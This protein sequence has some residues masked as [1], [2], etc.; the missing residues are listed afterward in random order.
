MTGSKTLFITTHN[1]SV[2]CFVILCF[3][4]FG[5]LVY[6]DDVKGS[7]ELWEQPGI[8]SGVAYNTIYG[9]LNNPNAPLSRIIVGADNSFQLFHKDYPSSGQ[10]YPRWQPSPS[11][12]GVFIHLQGSLY[13]PHFGDGRRSEAK[14]YLSS[15]TPWTLETLGLVTGNGSAS[16]PYTITVVTYAGTKLK[17]EMTLTYIDVD[18]YFRHDLKFINVSGGYLCFDALLGSDI[19]LADDDEGIPYKIPNGHSVGGHN[20]PLQTYT[21]LHIPITPTAASKYDARY[22]IDIWK[23]I[24]DN[25][26]D[27][28]IQPAFCNV[29][30][31]NGAAL[32]WWNLC[33]DPGDY[34]IIE[35]A[36]S[37]GEVPP[38]VVTEPPIC[39]FA[40]I[41]DETPPGY[42]VPFNCGDI[43]DWPMEEKI[44]IEVVGSEP[45]GHDLTLNLSN[46]PSGM[47]ASCSPWTIGICNP[48]SATEFNG[49][50]R[51]HIRLNWTPG[52]ADLGYHTVNATFTSE[53]QLSVECWFTIRVVRP[54]A[55]LPDDCVAWWTFDD[56]TALTY[57]GKYVNRDLI[58]KHYAYHEGDP[59]LL[60]PGQSNFNG[61]VNSAYFFDGSDDYLWVYNRPDLNFGPSVASDPGSGD[62]TIDAWVLIYPFL[63][64]QPIL[65]KQGSFTSPPD[66]LPPGYEFAFYNS[67]LELHFADAG[68]FPG[69]F[70][71]PPISGLIDVGWHHVA[72]T[73]DRD[74]SDGV[75]FYFDGSPIGDGQNPDMSLGDPGNSLPLLIARDVTEPISGYLSG[76][77]DELEIFKRSLSESE[78]AAIYKADTCGKCKE[79]CYVPWSFGFALNEQVKCVPVFVRNYSS[80]RH[81]YRVISIE[82]Q[83]CNAGVPGSAPAIQATVTPP[84]WISIE[85]GG[86]HYFTLEINRP[87]DFT[88]Q[89]QTVCYSVLI[90]NIDW[91]TEFSCIGSVFD[92][93]DYSIELLGLDDLEIISVEMGGSGSS[94]NL[95]VTNNDSLSDPSGELAYELIAVPSNHIDFANGKGMDSLCQFISINGQPPGTAASGSISIPYLGES[96]IPVNVVFTEHR[97]LV[98]YDIV[99]LADVDLDGIKEP[100]AVVPV[101]S[102][103]II[104][105]NDNG[106][107][108]GED[109]AEG[110]S[111]DLNENGI[112]DECELPIV[113]IEKT[114]GTLQGHYEYVTITTENSDLEMGGFDFLI[115]YDASALTAIGIEPCDLLKDCDWEYFTYRFGPFGN[116]GDACPSGLLRIVALADQNDG[117]NHPTCFGP[118]DTDPHELAIMQFLVTNNRNF[119]CQYAPIRFFWMDCGDNTISSVIGDSLFVSDHVYNV[120]GTEITDS[121][122]GYPT[123]FGVQSE[124]LINP[125]PDKP[126]PLRFIDF[127]NGGIDIICADSIDD[128]GDINLNGVPNEVADATMFTNYFVYGLSAFVINVEGQI[129]ASDVNADGMVLSVADLTY[130]IRV[131]VG[132]ALPYSKLNPIVAEYFVDDG[133]LSIDREIG[134]VYAVI[135][136]NANPVNLT[137]NMEMKFDYDSESGITKVLLYRMGKSQT[138]SNKFLKFKGTLLEIEAATYEG[139]IVKLTSD[140]LPENFVLHQNRPNP[141]NPITEISFSLPT[142]SDVVVNIFNINGQKVASVTDDHFEAGTHIVEWNGT[143]YASG[144]YL[145]KITAGD[146]TDTKKMM[147]L[148]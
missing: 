18:S 114:H 16:D 104:D 83:M 79:R 136:G 121:T 43:I 142:A 49:E 6:A 46:M 143:S 44:L 8:K 68:G 31:D 48:I 101:Q 82:S 22:Y 28:F 96:T 84:N 74:E 64:Y 2:I 61:Y 58:G 15:A 35:S 11:D 33:L 72:V 134:A 87:S 57:S 67:C 90:E 23:N 29:G 103:S 62:F 116:C 4:A 93:R 78:I 36:T 115:A 65:S 110:I 85:A 112:P 126:T 20:C 24:R 69:I 118:P 37:F 63:P 30:I 19:Y 106:I 120:E 98:V 81:N 147:L 80:E 128:R 127:V 9:Y 54:C 45:F 14:T 146:F 3:Y 38:F 70:H 100:M 139:A 95:L 145:Y 73:V 17:L 66:Y 7:R 21:F 88:A 32:K 141:F 99:L 1:K 135:K 51:L 129:A 52:K 109:V 122:Y 140:L 47:T 55:T 94:F 40:R 123:Y 92:N 138:F 50:E 53:S 75:M 144:V 105:C 42:S 137:G 77:L 10:I 133:I 39:E 86:K 12:M 102:V 76:N 97:P 56:K 113:R 89:G 5:F 25:D 111:S 117:P 34:L 148:K 60:P 124:C 119:D 91:G 108:D 41:P 107:D 59:V 27:N 13:S 125:Y 71:S 131:I 26:L 130:L 132:D